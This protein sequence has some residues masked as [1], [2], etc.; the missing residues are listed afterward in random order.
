MME[1]VNSTMIDG[2]SFF[3]FPCSADLTGLT[4]GNGRYRKDKK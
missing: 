1:G 3:S 4:R 2:V